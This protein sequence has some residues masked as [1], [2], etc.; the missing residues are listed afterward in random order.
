MLYFFYVL[1]FFFYTLDIQ[2]RNVRRPNDPSIPTI[3]IS[4]TDPESEYDWLLVNHRKP[5]SQP[6]IFLLKNVFLRLK[7]LKQGFDKEFFE[8]NYL[9]PGILTFR[10]NKGCI[11]TKILSQLAN[12]LIDEI[13]H[14]KR[15]F[16]HFAILKDKDF[17]YKS[18]SGLIIAKFKDYPFVIKLSIEHPHTIIQPFSTNIDTTGQFIIG[19]NFRHFSNFT[20]ITNLL[21]IQQ[22]LKSKRIDQ[23]ILDFP[24]KWYWKPNTC[25]DLKIVW[26]CNNNKEIINIPSAYA[27]IAD[28]I[29]T[30][31][32][33]PQ[34]ELNKFAMQIATAS[35][36]SIDPHAGNIVIEQH[37]QQYVLLDTEDFRILA[38]LEQNMKA[39]RYVG[40]YLELILHCMKTY[41][42]RTKQERINH[43][44]ML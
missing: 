29:Y 35:N 18:L 39:K 44:L 13:K 23:T 21:H 7:P 5:K 19:G 33:Q 16:S 32:L 27:T 24:R 11:D 14:R 40:W 38:G 31:K 20:R 26:T 41:F 6:P 2:T 1:S 10:N 4:S 8:K 28:F 22:L 30:D 25:H 36:F 12:E 43:S 42:F 17:N 3:Q 9:P 37:P 15:T 34:K